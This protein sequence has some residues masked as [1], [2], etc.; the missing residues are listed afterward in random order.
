MK[1]QRETDFLEWLFYMLH[2]GHLLCFKYVETLSNSQASNFYLAH[3]TLVALSEQKRALHTPLSSPPV[4]CAHWSMQSAF[5][6]NVIEKF[7][8]WFFLH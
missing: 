8:T 4:P 5:S 7:L 2:N 6:Q 1:F 3:G